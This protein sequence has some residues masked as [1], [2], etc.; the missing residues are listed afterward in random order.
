MNTE[1]I[2]RRALQLTGSMSHGQ[3]CFAACR[4]AGIDESEVAAIASIVSTLT[5]SLPAAKTPGSL[6]P[7]IDGLVMRLNFVKNPVKRA[8][9]ENEIAELTLANQ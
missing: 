3:A 2:A 8:A 5:H 9:I 7:R 1:N 4:E 6:Q